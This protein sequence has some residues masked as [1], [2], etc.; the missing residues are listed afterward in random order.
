MLQLCPCVA[1][2]QCGTVAAAGIGKMSGSKLSQEMRAAVNLG[3]V[4]EAEAI[5]EQRGPETNGQNVKTT[6]PEQPIDTDIANARRFVSQHGNEVRWTPERGWLVWNGV[7]WAPDALNAV[8]T[9]ALQ[10]AQAIFDEIRSASDKDE[11]F[12]WAKRSQ[13]GRAVR[14]MLYLA[15]SFEGIAT[16]ADIFDDHPWLLNCA[17]GVLD[18]KSGV[19]REHD[20]RL[21]MTRLVPVDYD[22]DAQTD[23]WSEF[24]WRITGGDADLQRFLQMAVGYSLTASTREQCLFFCYGHGANGKSVFLETLQAMLG[25]YALNTRTET[26][27]A[28]RDSGIP[29][30]VAR[31]A[32]ARMVAI[33]ETAENQKLHEPLVK[34]MTGGDTMTARFL[35]REFFDFRPAFKL[36]LRGN[37]KPEIHGTD[38]GIWRRIRLI[39][40][41]VTIPIEERDPD[42]AGK[43]LEELPGILAW[44]V[45]GCLAW[46]VEGFKIPAAIADAVREYRSEMDVLGQFIEDRCIVR[47]NAQVTAK[48]LYA[49]YRH[50]TDRAGELVVNQT[51]FGTAMT[52]RGFRKDRTRTGVLY[53]GLELQI[54][55]QCQADV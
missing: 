35:H 5:K 12:R 6:G 51:R 31:L 41:S 32:G 48:S 22:P 20:P 46:Q 39:P 40:F 17:N 26:I 4:T 53:H 16:H 11:I 36:W 28:R 8:N 30:D 2:H 49:A 18:L 15:Q 44:S 21:M 24:L 7:R 29:N 42:L 43:L 10:T 14:D 38:E 27:T 3:L 33:N 47:S 50:W 1:T 19:L 9:R 34:D 37:H 13:S 45:R 23:L 55:D 54:T 25:D 52:E